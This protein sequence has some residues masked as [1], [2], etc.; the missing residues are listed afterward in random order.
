MKQWMWR[1]D[2]KLPS[3]EAA[4]TSKLSWKGRIKELKSCWPW[5]SGDREAPPA[6]ETVSVGT[7]VSIQEEGVDPENYT[8]VWCG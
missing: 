2:R 8:I 3:N 7:T 6:A 5:R 4:K 1:V